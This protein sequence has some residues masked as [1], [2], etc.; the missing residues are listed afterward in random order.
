MWEAWEC[1]DQRLRFDLARR[2]LEVFPDC[3]EAGSVPAGRLPAEQPYAGV[4]AR[5][6]IGLVW[7]LA[8]VG[9]VDE[10]VSVC[11]ELLSEDP[12]DELGVRYVM[13]QVL[14]GAGR[15]AEVLEVV[16]RYPSDGS[17]AWLYTHALAAYGSGG[18][19]L[20]A[21]TA[22]DRALAANA[23][24][25][26]FLL[27]ER[28]PPPRFPEFTSAGDLYEGAAYFLEYKRFWEEQPGAIDFLRAAVHSG[29]RSES[30]AG[31][32]CSGRDPA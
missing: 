16:E 29:G 10:A 12:D 30:S 20:R 26:G 21:R 1:Q 32:A 5:A 9:E 4:V 3:A 13:T 22:V 31:E 23:Y 2:A 15:P 24:V 28:E 14:L 27:G 11:E 18:A 7:S 6:R 17:A 25:P 19:T 8:G